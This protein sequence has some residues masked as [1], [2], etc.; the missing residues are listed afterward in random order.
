MS[1]RLIASFAAVTFVGFS[2][3]AQTPPPPS[4][5]TSPAPSAPSP[6]P[7]APGLDDSWVDE[8]VGTPPPPAAPAPTAPASAAPAPASSPAG[9]DLPPAPGMS[10]DDVYYIPDRALPLSERDCLPATL[11]YRADRPVPKGYRVERRRLRGLIIS[12]SLVFGI[13]YAVSL[14]YA[15]NEP[16][17]NWLVVPVVGPLLASEAIRE[18]DDSS[19]ADQ[20]GCVYDTEGVATGLRFDGILQMIGAGL[21]IPGLAV[22]RPILVRDPTASLQITPMRLGHGHGVGIVG[23]F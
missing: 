11:S 21:L 22:R 9:G 14:A 1:V 10:M 3:S 12:G 16:Y 19:F 18:C 20:R 6:M 2:A 23:R 17:L 13:P 5:T 4:P 15:P 8:P 7:G